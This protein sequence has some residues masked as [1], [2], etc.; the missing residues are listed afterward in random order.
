MPPRVWLVIPTYN[1]AGGIERLVR[2]ADAQLAAAAPGAHRIL[3]VDD[4]SPDGTGEILDRLAGELATLAVLHRP[5]KGGLG[6]AY[7]A[8]FA[9]ALAGGAELVMQMDADFSHDPADLPRLLAEI[10]SCDMVLGSRYVPGGG[11]TDWGPVR[12]MLSRGGCLYARVLLGV[13]IR[14]LTG[15]LK[16]HRRAT[17][18]AIDLPTIGSQGYAFQ[19]EVTHRALR[20]GFDVR[21]IPIVFTDRREGTSKMSMPIAL[22]AVRMVPRLRRSQA[23]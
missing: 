3:V 6:A 8:G 19:I 22:E 12:R 20:R 13:S 18:E 7:R 21:E 17:L 4:N 15:G 2:A 10:E 9:A 16:C 11:V 5:G 1:E 14:D 23:T